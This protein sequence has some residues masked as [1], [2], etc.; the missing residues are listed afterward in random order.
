LADDAAVTASQARCPF[1]ACSTTVANGVD[2]SKREPRGAIVVHL[3]A[4]STV[5]A[6]IKYGAGPLVAPGLE[7]HRS[8]HPVFTDVICSESR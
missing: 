3:R 4:P 7:V 8:A 1:S 2:K 6:G 5:R